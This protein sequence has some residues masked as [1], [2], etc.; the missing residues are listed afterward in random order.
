MITSQTAHFKIPYASKYQKSYEIPP[1]STVLGMLKVLFGESIDDFVFGYSFE[2]GSKFNDVMNISKVNISKITNIGNLGPTDKKVTDVITV[3]YLYDCILNIY[4]D[5][6]LPLKVDY[7]L[8]MGKANNLAR[9]HL[10]F[11]K[12]KL[13]NKVGEGFNQYTPTS[14]GTGVIKPIT[15]IS[16]FDK[17][18]QSFRTKVK[19]LRINK[20]FKYDKN[21]DPESECN[22]F[23]WRYKGGEIYELS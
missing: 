17:R 19:H 21:Y 22:I 4:T 15:Y 9:L 13:I 16:E 18:I 12:V 10:P 23:L 20:E 14:V 5:I 11:K 2:Y 7:C 3:E 8:T 1:I 6:E